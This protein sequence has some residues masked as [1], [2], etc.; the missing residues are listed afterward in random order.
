MYLL[1]HVLTSSCMHLFGGSHTRSLTGSQQELLKSCQVTF[2]GSK[3]R[4]LVIVEMG[5]SQSGWLLQSPTALDSLQNG[6]RKEI[7][8]P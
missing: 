8:V 1:S 3:E 4:A 2:P 6:R 5:H 7:F